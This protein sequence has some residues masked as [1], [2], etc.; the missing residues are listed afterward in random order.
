MIS[1]LDSTPRPQVLRPSA[2]SQY[3]VSTLDLNTGKAVR[4]LGTGSPVLD[5]N[6]GSQIW[7]PVLD[8]NAG[9]HDWISALGP[10]YWISELDPSAGFQSWLPT[11]DLSIGSQ[12]LAL[13]LSTWPQYRA[14]QAGPPGLH[15]RAGLGQLGRPA[16]RAAPARARPI[17]RHCAR[18]SARSRGCTTGVGK[19]NRSPKDFG[20]CQPR[21]NSL[22]ISDD[23]RAG[24]SAEIVGDPC[25]RREI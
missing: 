7:T 24:L 17:R 14:C 4:D 3:W 18:A 16:A 12:Y 6:A 25:R 21:G 8:P 20:V 15:L 19:R 5:P 22:T 1:A 23:F 9:F 10:R 11:H 13:D 2:G